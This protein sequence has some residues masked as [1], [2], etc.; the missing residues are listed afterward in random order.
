MRVTSGDGEAVNTSVWVKVNEEVSIDP[1]TGLKKRTSTTERIL[2]TCTFHAIAVDE[3]PYKHRHVLSSAYEARLV[4]LDA[5]FAS[6]I[7]CNRVG[8]QIVVTSVRPDSL[9]SKEIHA[10]DTIVEVNGRL[11]DNN[12]NFNELKGPTTLKLVPAPVH[13]TPAVFYRALADYNAEDDSRLPFSWAG[14]SVK[15][16]EI[17]QVISKDDVWMQARKVNDISRVGLV[18]AKERI[19]RVAMLTPYGRRV[20]VLLGA[21]HVGRRSLKS[22]L[23]SHLPQYFAT[24]TPYTSRAPRTDEQEGREYYFRTKEEIMERIRAD[25]MVEWGEY[26]GH[27]YG[28]SVESIRACIRGGRVCV[29]D[30]APRALRYLYNGEFMPFVVVIASPDADELKQM[31]ALKRKSLSAEQ[32]QQTLD[33]NKKLLESD[34][35]S[36]FHLVLVNR[37]TDVTFRRILEALNDLKSEIQWIPESWMH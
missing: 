22:M 8:G 32:I 33:E 36:M 30:C 27:L 19:E 28:T 21:P 31:C 25:D 17:I 10:G 16:G 12:F 35:S 18:P 6:D 7:R 11:V 1:K 24:V 14:L 26:E 37:H 3:Q 5:S 15:K 29:L 34:E 13:Q 2:T 23:L 4:T 20:L 9:V